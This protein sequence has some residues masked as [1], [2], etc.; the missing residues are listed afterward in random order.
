[1]EIAKA[2]MV[3]SPNMLGAV[4]CVPEA[5]PDWSADLETTA[6]RAKNRLLD[7]A[8]EKGEP[9]EVEFLEAG[10]AN[11]S[12]DGNEGGVDLGRHPLVEVESGDHG[13]EE[14]FDRLDNVGKGNGSGSECDH[15]RQLSEHV[16]GSDRGHGL[17][18]G[19]CE[20]GAGAE[21]E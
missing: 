19:G 4:R 15:G 2:A 13:T 18:S 10:V 17:G 20:C 8:A 5:L 16:V 12:N 11:T 3:T 21:P 14:G 7:R 6:R 9:R 1:M